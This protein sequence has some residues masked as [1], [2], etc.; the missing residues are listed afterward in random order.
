MKRIALA[1]LAACGDVSDT[2]SS[3]DAG[4]DSPAE[5]PITAALPAAPADWLLLFDRSVSWFDRSDRFAGLVSAVSAYATS[6]PASIQLAATSFPRFFDANP[7]CTV[8]EYKPAELPWGTTDQEL[9]DAMDLWSITTGGSTLGPALQGAGDIAREYRN[10]NRGRSTSILLLTDAAPNED[11]ECESSDWAN[12]A[13][14]AASV[15]DGGRGP[16]IHVINVM[17]TAIAVDHTAKLGAIATAGGGYAAFVNGSETDV[18]NSTAD[19]LAELTERAAICTRSVP[20]GIVPTAI[21]V[22]SPDGTVTELA[23]ATDGASCTGNTFY[24]DD[25]DAPTTATLCSVAAG[26]RS[27]CELTF[28]RAHLSGAPTFIATQE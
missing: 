9:V 4:A 12:V 19:A 18:K 21:T 6:H 10:A 16:N 8:P 25:P 7:Y 14:I 22:T 23:R 28:L 20:A 17:G 13:S 5:A 26:V 1:L 2:P 15:Y 3:P 27:V 24:L 11:E